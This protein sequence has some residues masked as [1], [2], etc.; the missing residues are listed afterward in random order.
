MNKRPRQHAAFTLV[1]LMVA[2]AILGLMLFL[3]QELFQT[4]SVAITS[5]VQQSKAIA[6]G[7]SIGEQIED[8]AAAMLGPG[9][10]GGFGYLAIVSR[11]VP[12]VTMINPRNLTEVT[13]T[14]IR[15]DQIVF[16]R[17]AGGL[18]SMTP[19]GPDSY[20][21][22]L[23]GESGGYAKVWYGHPQ[24]TNNDGSVPGN[25]ANFQLGGADAGF[26]RIG[27]DW[28]LGRHAM[29]FNPTDA[30]ELNNPT[31]TVATIDDDPMKYTHADNAYYSSPVQR[32]GYSGTKRAFSGLTDVTRQSYYSQTDP[33]ALSFQLTDDLN[34]TPDELRD[35]ALNTAFWRVNAPLRVNPSPTQ[36]SYEAWAVAQSH[37]IF[38]SN[39]SDFIVEFAADVNGNGRIDVVRADGQAGGTPQDVGDIYWYDPMKFN[40]L[41]WQRPSDP[42]FQP[43]MGVVA[44]GGVATRVMVFRLDDDRRH[45]PNVRASPSSCWP[46]LIRIRYRIHG[47][48]GRLTSNDP[49]ALSDGLDNNGDGQV[50]EAGEDQIAGR[51][52]EHIIK[53]PR[54]EPL[55]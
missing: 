8:D 1:E 19:E 44:N 17:D 48:R 46:Y 43:D 50:D 24:R 49:G 18:R 7:R 30:V 12:N 5:S 13:V 11:R 21:S 9:Q 31:R 14:S 41:V 42:K 40:T 47:N 39:V 51:W 2:V 3:I 22:N 33:S 34:Q 35:A 55:P 25:A 16:I 45:N 20:R 37:P 10:A 28:I 53:V 27:I 4:T 54:P 52:F 36:T 23:I 15:S 29:L 26:D 6:S 38:A 32:T